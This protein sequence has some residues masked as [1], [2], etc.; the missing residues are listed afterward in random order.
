MTTVKNQ[1]TKYSALDVHWA[2]IAR[3]LQTTIGD[4]TTKDFLNIIEMSLLKDCGT[5]RKDILIA[6]GIFGPSGSGLKGKTT[7]P[8]TAHVW[9]D[10]IPVQD[11]ILDNY[12]NV[13]L[14]VD[15]LFVKNH[16][17]HHCLLIPVLH[18]HGSNCQ[19]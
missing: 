18:H 5:T 11:E 10:I 17:S 8:F 4:P 19:C 1:T 9:E 13:C 16:V 6:E 14:G 3:Q 2:T 12:H 15:L 7:T